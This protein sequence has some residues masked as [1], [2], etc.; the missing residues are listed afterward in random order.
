MVSPPWYSDDSVTVYAGDCLDVLRTLPDNSIDAV[1]TDPPYGLEFM[2]KDWDAPWK[3]NG[4]WTDKPHG[5]DNRL[6]TDENGRSTGLSRWNIPRPQY[7]A[8]RAFQSWC[9]LWAVECLRVLKPGGHM[10]AFGGTRTHHRLACAIEDAGFEI[11]DSIAWLYASGFPKSLDVSKAIDRQRDDK[12]DVDAVRSWLNAQRLTAG[13][14]HDAINAHFGHARNGGGSSSAWMTNPTS[15]ALPTC[16]QWQQLKALLRFGD[17]MDAEVWRLNGRKGTPGEAWDQRPITGQ[18]AQPDPRLTTWADMQGNSRGTAKERRDIPAT[19]AARQWQGWGTALKPAHEPIVV[20][21]KPLAGTVAQSVQQ[22]G[23]GALNIDATRVQ[24]QPGDYDHPGNDNHTPSRAMYEGGTGDNG[25]Q[26][27]P[28]TAGRWP[29]NVVLDPA[30]AA[31]LDRQSGDRPGM[32]TQRDLVTTESA[33]F[34]ADKH[35]G[36]REGYN[37]SGGGS[38]FFPVFRYEPKAPTYERPRVEGE[39]GGTLM[40][41][42][43]SKECNVCGVRLPSSSCDHDDFRRVESRTSAG[44]DHVAHPTVKPLDLMR[45]LVRLVTPPGGLVLDP[46]AGSGTTAEACVVEGFRCITI[47]REATYLPL[48]KA[49]LT[50]PIAL[51]LFGGGVA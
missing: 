48:I 36:E 40:S 41:G 35:P 34:G 6:P 14:S 43:S 8:G 42:T 38:R 28:H 45:W 10:L 11:R 37:D 50:K 17:D 7:V 51:D 12:S 16:E 46:F 21:R 22:W 30:A 31:E 39:G 26:R 23:T 18:H 9:E 24:A 32:R 27:P 20:A 1:C 4:R 15:R 13:L 49:R 47:E 44:T 3:E 33:Y 25:R 19:D 5:E 29:P 2:G